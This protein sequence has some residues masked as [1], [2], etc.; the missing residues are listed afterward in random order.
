MSATGDTKRQL[1][2]TIPGSMID[3]NV[4]NSDLQKDTEHR[5]GILGIA[6]IVCSVLAIVL[7]VWVCT[8]VHYLAKPEWM[9][10]PLFATAFAVFLLLAAAFFACLF[11]TIHHYVE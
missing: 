6:G 8:Y 3:S 5:K 2:N 1:P 7:A 9:K 10:A 11:W 4:I